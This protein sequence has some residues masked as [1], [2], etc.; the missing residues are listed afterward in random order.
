MGLVGGNGGVPGGWGSLVERAGWELSLWTA[1]VWASPRKN[2]SLNLQG[3][4][5]DYLPERR[6]FYWFLEYQNGNIYFELKCLY[7]VL[8]TLYILHSVCISHAWDFVILSAVCEYWCT[9]YDE[10]VTYVF[11]QMIWI[12]T[13]STAALGIDVDDSVLEI[14]HSNFREKYFWIFFRTNTKFNFKTDNSITS[15]YS[16]LYLYC[17]YP[18]TTMWVS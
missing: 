17:F 1:A 6:H 12:E 3:Y 14:T 16:R 5:L 8:L 11:L 9:M 18:K 7:N 10:V 4:P 15:F 2:L 13:G